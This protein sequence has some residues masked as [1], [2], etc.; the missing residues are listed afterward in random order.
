MMMMMMMTMMMMMMMMMMMIF[1]GANCLADVR[2][3]T[4]CSMCV[5]TRRATTSGPRWVAMGSCADTN[6]WLL[7]ALAVLTRVLPFY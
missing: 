1:V 3:S 7:L 4:R 6:L 5:A 2:P